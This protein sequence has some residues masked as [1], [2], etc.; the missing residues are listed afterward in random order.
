M[1]SLQQ[2]L[3][4]QDEEQLERFA[5][6]WAL[7]DP[8][9]DGW[10]HHRTVFLQQFDDIIAARFAWEALTQ[11]E[12]VLLY[13]LVGAAKLNWQEREVLAKN[14]QVKLPTARFETALASLKERFFVQEE[15]A[16]LQGD[17][18]I[19]PQV[20][21]YSYGSYNSKNKKVP[22]RDATILY[23][24]TE[25]SDAFY[26]V[27]RE[28][29]PAKNELQPEQMTLEQVLVELPASNLNAIGS[30]YGWMPYGSPPS[31]VKGLAEMLGQPERISYSLGR[32]QL[33][34]VLLE[35][36]GWLRDAGGWSNMQLVRERFHI[37]EGQLSAILHLLAA[38]ALA[39]D[40]FRGQERVLFVPSDIAKKMADFVTQPK[41]AFPVGLMS[42][43]TPPALVYSG[44]ALTYNDVALLVGT[45][46]QQNIE[47]T[48][49]GA[50]PKRIA[51]KITPLLKGQERSKYE[52]PEHYYLEMLLSEMRRLS[53]IELSKPSFSDGKEHYVPGPELAPWANMDAVEQTRYLLSCW[54]TSRNWVDVPG[55]NFRA[56]YMYYSDT[57][58]ARAPLLAYLKSSTPGVWYT[59]S[60]L[61]NTI[62]GT[63]P[64]ILHPYE[65]GI[66][67]R[68]K[69]RQQDMDEHWETR[70]AQQ[71]IGMLS[72]S[73]YELGIVAIG[74]QNVN[75]VGSGRAVNPDAFMLTEMGN[76]ILNELTPKGAAPVPDEEDDVDDED[77]ED[78]EGFNEWQ[79]LRGAIEALTS[80]MQGKA[81]TKTKAKAKPKPEKTQP[82]PQ[83]ERPRA[84]IVQ[85]NFELLLMQPDLPTLYS[86]LPFAQVNALGNVSHLTLTRSSVLRGMNF[87]YTV[88]RVLQVLERYSQ[89]GIPQN[90]DYTLR[91]WAKAYRAVQV[92]QVLLIEVENETHANELLILPKLKTFKLRRIGPTILAAS[93]DVNLSE[94]RRALEKEGIVVNITGTIATAPTRRTGNDY[95]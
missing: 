34:P 57:L 9:R 42:L 83:L 2:L 53:L 95:Y 56:N 79:D 16:K 14:V 87:D 11:D 88:E 50:V 78:M 27:S 48:K 68:D 82:A 12:R 26:R 22:E 43:D 65:R 45:I 91:D 24:P 38:Y 63:D 6:L 75:A 90:V 33:E 70:D 25:I 8:P 18:L 15:K 67:F 69:R 20:N 51:G 52:E 80:G 29:F 37:S 4:K 13:G 66:V 74:Y 89:K 41:S 23:V 59:V 47:P 39:F 92:S 31:S 1:K 62:R 85:P 61:L 17:R 54:L 73:L 5:K 94:L 3:A 40:R 7:A 19:D 77:M 55:A 21:F 86:L 46:Y 58:P 44:D 93:S 49:A 32:L 36:L 84:L 64:F 81:P 72:S 10:I 71:L 28:T 30:H 60:S 76:T 35:F